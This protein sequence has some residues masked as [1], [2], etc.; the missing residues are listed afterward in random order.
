MGGYFDVCLSETKAGADIGPST[1]ASSLLQKKADNT[2]PTIQAVIH[3]RSLSPCRRGSGATAGR[4]AHHEAPERC[5][6]RGACSV[7]RVGDISNLR[8]MRTDVRPPRDLQSRRIEGGQQL[9]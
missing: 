5:Q 2:T 9:G 3:A 6:L 4:S 7:E 8:M 1:P